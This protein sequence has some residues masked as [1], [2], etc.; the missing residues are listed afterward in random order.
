[1]KNGRS[2]HILTFLA[3]VLP[4]LVIEY[5]SYREFERELLKGVITERQ[6][7]VSLSSTIL[8]ERFDRVRELAMSLSTRVA[9]RVHVRENRWEQ[10]IS[11]LRDVPG[12]FPFVER[13]FIA[14]TLG[15]LMADS[16]ALPNARN[17]NFAFRDW[18]KGVRDHWQPYLSEVYTRAASPKKNVV[19]MSC[20]IRA[21]QNG[22]VIGILVLQLTLETL[23]D[24]IKAV[25]V[26]PDEVL[27]VVDHK[28]NVAAHPGHR[29]QGDILNYAHRPTVQSVLRGQQEVRVLLDPDSGRSFLSAYAPVAG[30]GWG[31]ITEEPEESAFASQYASLRSVGIIYVVVL[32]LAFL[33]AWLIV[34]VFIENQRAKAEILVLNNSLQR[35]AKELESANQELEAFSYS[36]SHDLRAPLRH[37]DGFT[38]ILQDQIGATANEEQNRLLGIISSSAK[39]LGLLIDELLVFSRIARSEMRQGLVPMDRLIREVLD[40]TKTEIEERGVS[41]SVDDVPAVSGDE[42]MLRQ[43]WINLISNALKFTG[44]TPNPQIRIRYTRENDEHVFCVQD[45]GAGFDMR[46]VDKLFGVFQRLHVV[47]EFE[48]TGIGLAHVKRIITRHHGRVWAKGAVGQ[49]AEF[50]FSLPAEAE[51]PPI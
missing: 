23:L 24:W 22:P 31:V 12:D 48:G 46:Y 7:V 2:L 15:T 4:L 9:F 43:V 30:Y 10:A 3:I 13:M 19:A 18:Y 36:V 27:Y 33:M 51:T 17:V 49:G 32:L 37:I 47:D 25:P 6:S 21:S 44:K 42:T 40:L 41:V 8:K 35:R 1:M 28:G 20:P 26:G 14:D 34:R 39:K 29:L 38:R 16:P 50:C 11:I 45:N 5:F